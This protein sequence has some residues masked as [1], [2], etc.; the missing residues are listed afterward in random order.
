PLAD[1]RHY[2]RKDICKILESY[3]GECDTDSSQHE[4]NS[5]KY[6]IDHSEIDC[7]QKYPI[8]HHQ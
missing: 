5:I 6:E 2:E 7:A 3:G 4:P 1:A 8:D